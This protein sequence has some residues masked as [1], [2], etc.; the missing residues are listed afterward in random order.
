[1]NAKANTTTNTAILTCGSIVREVIALRDRHGW[2]ADVWALPAQLHGTP[3][4]IPAAVEKRLAELRERYEH[5]VLAYG[6]CGTSG[7]LDEVLARIG[8]QRVPGLHCYEMFSDGAFED[9][10]HEELGTYFFTDFM[11]RQFDTVLVRGLG[12]DRYPELRDVYFKG[13]KRVIY[14]AQDLTE[15]MRS[16]AEAAAARIG[17]PLEIR[18]LGMGALEPRLVALMEQIGAS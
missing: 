12:L 11:V 15:E 1:M 9:I 7:E 4:K 3:R 8:V 2:P 17:L 6:D 18:E 5:V 13:Y 16:K 10:L 14:F